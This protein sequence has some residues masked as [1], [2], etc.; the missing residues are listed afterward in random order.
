[1]QTTRVPLSRTKATLHTSTVVCDAVVCQ[2][3]GMLN[4]VMFP[5][6]GPNGGDAKGPRFYQLYMGHDDEIVRDGSCSLHIDADNRA[7][8]FLS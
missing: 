3:D 5:C 4:T 7:R 1:M 6:A 2:K 8:L